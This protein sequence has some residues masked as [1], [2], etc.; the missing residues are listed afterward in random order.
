MMITKA[1]SQGGGHVFRLYSNV[2]HELHGMCKYEIC[3]DWVLRNFLQ[4]KDIVSALAIW[5][6]SSKTVV[7]V[8][9]S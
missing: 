1:S 3:R 2:Q 7:R 4:G 6:F 5:S 8:T 9:Q